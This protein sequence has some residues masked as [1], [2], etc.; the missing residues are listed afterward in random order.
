MSVAMPDG[1]TGAQTRPR[2]LFRQPRALQWFEDGKT[3]VQKRDCE[4][5]QAGMIQLSQLRT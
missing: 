2:A 3:G 4:E 5:R 1:E